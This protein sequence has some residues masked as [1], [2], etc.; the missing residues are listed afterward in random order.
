MIKLT[1]KE[2]LFHV[3]LMK[4]RL[5]VLKLVVTRGVTSRVVRILQL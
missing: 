2:M 1:R 5:R 3:H 4:V